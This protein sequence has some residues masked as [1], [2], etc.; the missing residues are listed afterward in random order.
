MPIRLPDDATVVRGGRVSGETLHGGCGHHEGIFGF[1]VQTW[2]GMSIDE[3]AKAGDV[4]HSRLA[5]TTVRALRA[6]GC[7]VVPTR[8]WG[9]HATVQVPESW[10][11][12]DASKLVSLFEI[13]ENPYRRH[14]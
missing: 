14:G 8:G 12:E 1:S 3:L 5:V 4:P 10:S 9:R 13:M 2:P 11:V 6:A 7:D